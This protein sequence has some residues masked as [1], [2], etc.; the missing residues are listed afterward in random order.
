MDLVQFEEAVRALARGIQSSLCVATWLEL[1]PFRS[2]LEQICHSRALSNPSVLTLPNMN[3]AAEGF[4]AG[5]AIPKWE[6]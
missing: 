6:G 5:G 4:P 2:S 1:P 3:D